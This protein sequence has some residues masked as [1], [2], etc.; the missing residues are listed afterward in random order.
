MLSDDRLQEDDSSGRLPRETSFSWIEQEEGDGEEQVGEDPEETLRPPRRLEKGKGK[1]RE[2]WPE[3]DEEVV[4]VGLGDVNLEP[5]LDASCDGRPQK[6][7]KKDTA[8]QDKATKSQ[9]QKEN[10]CMLRLTYDY[11]PQNHSC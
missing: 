2:E 4:T 3:Q 7:S 1:S 8:K 11:F 10:K 9:R 6:K 5:E